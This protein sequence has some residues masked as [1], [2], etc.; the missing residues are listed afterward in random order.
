MNLYYIDSGEVKYFSKKTDALDAAQEEA[1]NT[2]RSVLVSRMFIAI[3]R[4][5][6]TRL[7]N[8]ENGFSKF[9]GRVCVVEP[10]KRPRIKLRRVAAAATLLLL[11]ML[12]NLADA[13]TSCTTRRS[14]SVTIT[15][16]HSKNSSSHCRS[17]Y[18]GSVLKTYCR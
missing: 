18:S 11:L 12:P 17:Y 4:D 1:D 5:N 16:C 7:A 14:G 2:K 9:V 3:D 15:T 13:G 10:R 8:K 6:V